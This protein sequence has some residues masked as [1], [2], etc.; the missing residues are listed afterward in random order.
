MNYLCPLNICKAAFLACLTSPMT[1]PQKTSCPDELRNANIPQK[2]TNGR[3]GGV[4]AFEG[5]GFTAWR[6]V[7]GRQKGESRGCVERGW[8]MKW[9]KK[10]EEKR[11][12]KRSRNGRNV[13]SI[14]SI[15]CCIPLEISWGR[16][17]PC[18]RVP[19]TPWGHHGS[20]PPQKIQTHHCKT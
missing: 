13:F 6:K 10:D 1:S 8:R 15:W 19:R 18:L 4:C 16:S 14:R 2:E 3:C 7:K 17:T 9:R 12:R 20:I 5:G 11:G